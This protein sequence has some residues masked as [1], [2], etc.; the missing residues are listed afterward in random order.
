MLYRKLWF[1]FP[2]APVTDQKRDETDTDELVRKDFAK[3]T[4]LTGDLPKNNQE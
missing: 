1:N 3:W 2:D 4:D